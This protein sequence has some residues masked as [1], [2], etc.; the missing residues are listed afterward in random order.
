MVTTTMS[1]QKEAAQLGW[2]IAASVATL[3]AV[4][5]AV[6]TGPRALIELPGRSQPIDAAELTGLAAPVN[7]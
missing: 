4:T 2:P 1:L 7:A 6:Q 3:R 5:G